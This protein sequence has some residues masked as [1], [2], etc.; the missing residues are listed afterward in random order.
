MAEA[1]VVGRAVAAVHADLRRAFGSRLVSGTDADAVFDSLH[2][3]WDTVLAETPELR[4]HAADVRAVFERARAENPTLRVQRTHGDLHLGQPLRTARGWVVIDLEG[5]PMAPF[6]ER[7]RLRPTHRDVAGMLRSFD[8]AAGHRLLAVERESGDDEPS[9]SGAGPVADAAGRELAVAAA[10]QDAFC[11]GYARVL[12]G[13][14][15]RP[16]L[17]RALRLEKA[18]YEV[19]YELANRPSCLGSPSRLCAASSG[20]EPLPTPSVC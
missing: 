20:A 7:E 1:H 8:Y 14:R 2:H 18:V 19:A 3:R 6:E 15:G 4:E 13:P 11:A 16:A 5:E 12:D 10:R 17:L 9:T